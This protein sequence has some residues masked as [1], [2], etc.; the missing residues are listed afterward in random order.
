MAAVVTLGSASARPSADIFGLMLAAPVWFLAHDA[1]PAGDKAASGWPARAE[2][3][4]PPARKD[5]GECHQDRVDLRRWWIE[6]A[7][8]FDGPFAIE[9]RV[10][11]RGE[12]R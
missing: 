9:E 11:I 4:R 3:I 1:D 8:P 12:G 2:R 6:N 5:W 10:A 7:F